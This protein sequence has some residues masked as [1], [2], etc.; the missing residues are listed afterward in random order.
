LISPT[1]GNRIYPVAELLNSAQA[2]RP[3]KIDQIAALPLG[4]RIKQSYQLE[5]L[6]SKNPPL[7]SAREKMPPEITP[8]VPLLTR[9]QG[10]KAPAD[11]QQA[12]VPDK[13][14]TPP[15]PKE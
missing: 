13:G 10:K 5:L 7:Q 2:L 9:F 8:F 1:L 12:V 14:Q 6:K 3:D 15:Q 4:S 11:S